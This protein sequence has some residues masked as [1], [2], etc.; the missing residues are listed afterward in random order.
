MKRKVLVIAADVTLRGAVAT[1]LQPEGYLVEHSANEERTR[2]L[3]DTGGF[4]AAVVAPTSLG[5]DGV[6]LLSLAKSKLAGLHPGVVVLPQDL[7]DEGK[8]LVAKPRVG[9]R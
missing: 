6:K 1:I 4:D 7:I 8:I 3:L 5:A 9:S 2:K